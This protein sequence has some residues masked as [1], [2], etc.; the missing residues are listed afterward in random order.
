MGPRFSLLSIGRRLARGQGSW[1]P[2]FVTFIISALTGRC[3]KPTRESIH[4]NRTHRRR[5]PSSNKPIETDRGHG[6]EPC[7]KLR[8]PRQHG[9]IAQEALKPLDRVVQSGERQSA[10]RAASLRSAWKRQALYGELSQ[11][12]RID[13]S[14]PHQVQKLCPDDKSQFSIVGVISKG[15][16]RLHSCPYGGERPVHH[17][18]RLRIVEVLIGTLR[19]HLAPPCLEAGARPNS[20]SHQCL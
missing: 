7:G 13:D 18:E 15:V 17:C 6:D 12:N 2:S 9:V 4:Q 5:A 20:L 14:I 3:S 19:V 1:S 16:V 11:P 8:P 10:E